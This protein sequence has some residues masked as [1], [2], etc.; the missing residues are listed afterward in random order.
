MSLKGKRIILALSGSIAAYKAVYLLR[1]LKKAEA[2]VKIVTTAS[3]NHFVGELTLSSLSGEKVF[4][5]LWNE[6][7]SEHVSLGT[8]ADLMVVAPATANTLAKLANGLCDNA[9]TAVYLAARCPVMVAPA[10]DADM[11]IHPRTQANLKTLAQDGVQV[12]PTGT[13]FLASGLEGPGR[14]LEPEEIF[15]AIE[16]RLAKG[17]LS[18]QKV[19]VSA[20]PTREALDPVRFISNRS[21]GKMGYALA[22]AAQQLGAEVTLVSGPTNLDAPEGVNFIPVVSAA[23]MLEAVQTN[24]PTQ[25][26]IVMAAAVADYTPTS[27]ADQKM[28]KKDGDLAIPLKRTVDILRSLGENKPAG[29]VL[30]GFA[31]E[32]QNELENAQKKLVAKKLDFVVL[33]SLR[34]AGAGFGHDTNRVTLIHR[35]KRV[36][37]LPLMAKDEVA[38]AIWQEVGNI[39]GLR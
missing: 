33:N 22:R 20:G 2:V 12:L 37:A 24:A 14:L 28:K 9:L 6:N 30:V 31:M 27:I 7:W 5:N 8:W 29:Q 25:Q 36:Q 21:S 23:D 10:M 35:D 26:A 39:L 11:M 16:K 34:E 13:G 4:S 15:A 18:G 32:T 17:I 19:L 3:V 1:L 38:Q